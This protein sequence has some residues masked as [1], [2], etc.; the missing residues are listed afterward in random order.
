VVPTPLLAITDGSQ[1]L[2]IVFWMKIGSVDTPGAFVG[3]FRG[4]GVAPETIAEA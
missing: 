2:L 3:L 4:T 1:N